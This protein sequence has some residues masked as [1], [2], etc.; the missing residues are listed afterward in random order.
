MNYTSM[1]W[2]DR[3]LFNANGQRINYTNMDEEIVGC[4]YQ[5]VNE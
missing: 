5:M 3:G 1:G 2:R 4:L